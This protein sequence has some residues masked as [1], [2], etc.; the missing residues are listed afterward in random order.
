MN[1]PNKQ[2]LIPTDSVVPLLRSLP[3]DRIPGYGGKLGDS[4]M[5]EF[6]GAATIGEIIS[7]PSALQQLVNKFGPNQAREIWSAFHGIETEEVKARALQAVISAGKQFPGGLMLVGAQAWQPGGDIEKWISNLSN[8]LFERLVEERD[9]HRRQ[10]RTLGISVNMRA[11][12]EQGAVTDG[13][14]KN[15]S[16][17]GQMPSG[18]LSSVSIAHAATSLLKDVMSHMRRAQGKEWGISSLFLRAGGFVTLADQKA[19]ITRFFASS[20]HSPQKKTPRC[21]VQNVEGATQDSTKVADCMNNDVLFSDSCTVDQV[22]DANPK[23]CSVSTNP[24]APAK[25]GGPLLQIW[26]KGRQSRV[27]ESEETEPRELACVGNGGDVVG[28]SSPRVVVEA[29][30]AGPVDPYAGIRP[31]DIDA[32]FLGGLPETMVNEILTAISSRAGS[33]STERV[34]GVE[35][36]GHGTKRS[37]NVVSARAPVLKKP[38]SDITKY[39]ST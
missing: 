11:V 16:E 14:T 22:E 17:S 30:E 32:D 39:F 24:V 36:C 4:I 31:E 12:D 6:G 8:Q 27:A 19:A 23:G 10:A 21:A 2:A 26:G 13:D 5:A 29:C 18:Q 34:R 3:V 9:E 28:T 1:K 35:N 7:V 15:V 20:E 38:K 25:S 37:V 33:E